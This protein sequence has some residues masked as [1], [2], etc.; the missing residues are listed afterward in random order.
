MWNGREDSKSALSCV[1]R[2][3]LT[4]LFMAFFNFS[5][6]EETPNLVKDLLDIFLSLPRVRFSE[7]VILYHGADHG[8][9]MPHQFSAHHSHQLGPVPGLSPGHGSWGCRC[10]A[11]PAPSRG[12]WHGHSTGTFPRS[13]EQHRAALSP[14]V[15]SSARG[16]NA[17]GPVCW[18]GPR[19]PDQTLQWQL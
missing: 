12:R 1:L 9:G 6:L 5:K 7:S 14:P 18:A 4:L 10:W 13:W 11:L 15:C 19:L 3:I 2:G 17:P 16:T 8:S